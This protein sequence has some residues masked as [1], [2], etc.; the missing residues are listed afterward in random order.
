M[1]RGSRVRGFYEL[2]DLYADLSWRAHKPSGK[3]LREKWLER[4]FLPRISG[5][6]CITSEMEQR[7]RRIFPRQATIARPLGT[8]SL[9]TA[10]V[11]T[12]RKARTVFYVGHMHG[13]KG[14][15]FLEK[16]AIALAGKGVRTEFWGGYE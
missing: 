1:C 14:V 6:V 8:D 12:R 4:L 13:P 2:H 15:S 16:A 11:E 10:D 9:P 3:E 5:L 7:Y